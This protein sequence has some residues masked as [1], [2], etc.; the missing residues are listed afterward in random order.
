MKKKV[1]GLQQI[2]DYRQEV[3]KERS[4]E[5]AAARNELA[6][7]ANLL[8]EEEDSA[9]QL[10]RELT[11]K[12]SEGISSD[13][14]RLY[15]DFSLH[16]HQELQRQRQNVEQLGRK[17]EEKQQRLLEAAKEKKVLETY[18]DKTL[19]RQRKQLAQREQELLDEIAL[20]Q[21]GGGKP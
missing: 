17:A 11:A 13:E 8:Q 5:F 2:L 1:F 12:Q 6:R 16:Q 20:Q 3:E 19:Q 15:A 9:R 4:L 21:S 10:A 18:R 14:L 7:A